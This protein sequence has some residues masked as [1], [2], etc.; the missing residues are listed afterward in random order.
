M[1]IPRG[2]DCRRQSDI[3]GSHIPI[4]YQP[5]SHLTAACAASHRA[6]PWRTQFLKRAVVTVDSQ[7]GGGRYTPIPDIKFRV[8]QSRDI[9]APNLQELFAAG[10]SSQGEVFDPF[11]NT[12]PT[13]RGFATGNLALKP[14]KADT[15]GIGVVV[16]PTFIPG[17]SAS[18]DW[19]R[20]KVADA[21]QNVGTGN[22][23]R[24]CFEGN[25]QFCPNI[26]RVNGIITSVQTSPFNIAT[27]ITKGIDIEGTYRFA[28]DD[29]LSGWVGNV[30]FH[31]N[32]TMYLKDLNDDGITVPT[33]N[34]GQNAGSNPPNWRYSL[35]LAYDA[36]PVAF[37]LTARAVSSGV[38]NSS[39]IECQTGCPTSTTVNQ[40]IN[41]NGIPG[42]F[43]MDASMS[44][45]FGI[46][47]SAQGE[48][49]L[50]VRNL[51]NVDPPKIYTIY[52][53]QNTNQ[54]AYD[55]L[56]RVFRAGVRF[57]M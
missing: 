17:F 39:Y 31:G 55:A 37:S 41:D 32:A 51:G 3:R 21:I 16:Q 9:R 49:F 35:T 7:K 42:R 10:T 15:T 20:I 4:G 2:A 36:E 43:Y 48:A 18:V 29:V 24:L 44:Y 56:G 8:T 50:N 5:R 11:T 1:L 54:S 13:V 14:E 52:Y 33:D 46:G 53:L 40:T 23:V 19:W 57:R 27:S 30:V 34:V 47:D 28:L 25:Q 22:V 6:K 26:T 45:Q 38:Y 12:N